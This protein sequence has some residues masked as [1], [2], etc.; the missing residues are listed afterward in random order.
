MRM[1]L[2]L[3]AGLLA[4]IACEALA[5][6]A[7][8]PPALQLPAGARV[9]LRTQASPAEWIKGTLA[10][11][12]SGSI[13][14]VPEGAPPLGANVLRLPRGSVTRLDLV[15]GKKRQWL[16]G[17]LIGGA[18]GVAMGF[19][20]DVDPVRCEFDDNYYCSRGGAVAAM[21]VGSAAMGA[22]IGALIRKDVWM[23]VGLDA[24]GPPPARVTLAGSGLRVVPGG[25]ALAV[26]VRF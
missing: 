12:D 6:D 18:L 25:L 1:T 20:M 21:G 8:Q 17:L 15:T 2:P 14:V 10:S 22:G 19:A 4:L 3:A 16:P 13:A 26:S 24:L 5:Q 11:A 23:P 7:P 9:R